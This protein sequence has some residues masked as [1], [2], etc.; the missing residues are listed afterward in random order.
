MKRMKNDLE[1]QNE[2]DISKMEGRTVFFFVFLG[3]LTAAMVAV[4]AVCLP[5]IR[6]RKQEAQEVEEI[7]SS[8]F[9]Y[10]GEATEDE[11]GRIAET[12]RH[13]LILGKYYAEDDLEYFEYI[14]NTAKRCLA[15]PG[16]L[17][18]QA[19]LLALNTGQAYSLDIYEDGMEQSGV[20]V[21][22]GYDEISETSLRIVADRNSG[23][24]VAVINGKRGIVSVHRMKM[25]FCDDCIYRIL[26]VN[27]NVLEPELILYNGAENEFYPIEGGAT[28]LCGEYEVQV[29]YGEQGEYELEILCLKEG[30]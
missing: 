7:M 23:T 8:I 2:D 3:C 13:D 21:S 28:Y 29:S 10:L 25:L 12:I 4:I 9:A 20:Q 18:Y 26:Q 22:W 14:P 11:Y 19:C 15:E 6:S 24:G 17:P 1:K 30:R 27:E 16:E 5:V